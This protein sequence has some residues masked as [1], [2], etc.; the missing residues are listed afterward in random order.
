MVQILKLIV[1]ILALYQ[2][3]GP[4]GS[5]GVVAGLFALLLVLRAS[6]DHLMGWFIQR[7]ILGVGRVLKDA[8]VSI[9]AVTPAPEPDPS[10]WRTGDD[11][12]DEQ[13]EKDLDASGMPE[14]DFDWARIDLTVE[15]KPNAHGEPVSWEPGLI[16]LRQNDGA[17]REALELD[18]HCLVAQVEVW[19]D[20][21]FVPFEHGSL[22]RAA[23]LRLHVG[24]TP[25]THEVELNYLGERLAEVRLPA[26]AR[27]RGRTT[28]HPAERA[29][30]GLLSDGPSLTKL[31]TG[32]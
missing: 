8:T 19:K 16:L 24:V 29:L 20:N 31:E 23:R 15:P 26:Q 7:S 18:V 21:Q 3:L 28:S 1:V 27:P 22:E 6:G 4:W 32:G 10:V 2:F 12:E 25:G 13:F 30:K 14:G 5:L 11:D 17:A 9:H